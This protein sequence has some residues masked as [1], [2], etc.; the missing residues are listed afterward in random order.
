MCV[1]VNADENFLLNWSRDVAKDISV[2]MKLFPNCI[3]KREKGDK[4]LHTAKSKIAH[5]SHLSLRRLQLPLVKVVGY[6]D[7]EKMLPERW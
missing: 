5:F 7:Q 2:Q 3:L 6:G 1:L 4:G